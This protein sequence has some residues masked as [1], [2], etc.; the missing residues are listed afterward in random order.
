MGIPPSSTLVGDTSALAREAQEW[1]VELVKI[2]TTNPPG[3]EEAAAKYI[4][5][6]LAKEGI[7][8]EL[9]P[10]APGRSALVARLR[11]TMVPDPSKALLLVAHMDTVGV[12][13]T[14]WSVDP[15]A[16]IIKDG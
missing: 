1:L 12:D 7:Q 11:S 3:N 14:K 13:R 10:A 16:G 6:I 2:N 4:A 9:L 15:Y 8:A 5:S